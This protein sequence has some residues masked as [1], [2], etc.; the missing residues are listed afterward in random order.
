MCSP[1]RAWVFAGVGAINVVLVG[2]CFG[3]S[4]SDREKAGSPDTCTTDVE[5]ECTKTEELPLDA[6]SALGF[7][8]SEV[9]PNIVGNYEIPIRWVSPCVEASGCTAGA[10][11]S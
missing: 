1:A 6:V 5:V 11:C 3:G 10:D 8:A 7:S 2:A 9:L 4:D